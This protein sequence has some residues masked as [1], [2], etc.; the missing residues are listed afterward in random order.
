M[1][2]AM[3]DAVIDAMTVDAVIDAVTVETV[4]D[5]L[6]GAMVAATVDAKVEGPRQSGVQW[7]AKNKCATSIVAHLSKLGSIK[8]AVFLE[9]NFLGG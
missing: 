5:A 9:A 2:D 1:V 8:C 3:V 7:L 6:A 4:I